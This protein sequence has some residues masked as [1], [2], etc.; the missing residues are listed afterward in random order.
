[1]SLLC[2]HTWSETAE[3]C[4]SR[5]NV[6]TIFLKWQVERFGAGFAFPEG[7]SRCDEIE[8]AEQRYLKNLSF[9]EKVY[10]WPCESTDKWTLS[11]NF[12]YLIGTAEKI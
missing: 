11:V 8:I 12:N 6:P 2:C 7:T 1:M 10:L 5:H 4:R 9:Y 3:K